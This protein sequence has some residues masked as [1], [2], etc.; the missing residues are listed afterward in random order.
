[1][2]FP[3]EFSAVA[4]MG[5]WE[6]QKE[7]LRSSS[8]P[9]TNL[10]CKVQDMKDFPGG[11]AKVKHEILEFFTAGEHICHREGVTDDVQEEIEDHWD[12]I[13][14][15]FNTTY[16]C[17]LRL[18]EGDFLKIDPDQPEGR[19]AFEKQIDKLSVYELAAIHDIAPITESVVI[20][21]ALVKGFL[22]YKTAFHA[23][24][25]L[26]LYNINLGGLVY[27]DHDLLFANKNSRFSTIELFLELIRH[28]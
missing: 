28:K 8:L 13:I 27:G 4:A 20:A 12:P 21:I 2:I 7:F 22:D 18:F 17:K 16:G 19:A 11:M 23:S 15:W 9:L 6:T 25:L 10:F 24:Q 5:E 1:V 3:N 14:N 26:T